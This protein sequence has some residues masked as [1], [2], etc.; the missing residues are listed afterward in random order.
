MQFRHPA[1][2]LVGSLACLSASAEAS[3]AA[4]Q[5]SEG[6]G[7]CVTVDD[8]SARLACYDKAFGRVS[9]P[10]ASVAAP[11]V[12]AGAGTPVSSPPTV[13]ASAAAA[14]AVPKSDPIA[15][16]GLSEKAKLAKD[17][18]KAA[19]HPQSITAQ[20]ASVR[21]LKY[22]ELVVTLDNGQVWQQIEAQRSAV[23]RAGDTVTIRR[24][25]LGSFTLVTKGGIATKV[26]RVD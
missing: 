12:T 13:G 10:A 17:P 23:V 19:E 18:A 14:A 24:A 1:A 20:V 16:F 9:L 3:A 7:A 26:R 8:P 6:A 15:D 25:V 11:Q 21:A 4:T 2:A 22:G 5:A